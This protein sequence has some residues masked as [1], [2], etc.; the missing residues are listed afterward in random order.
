MTECVWGRKDY[1]GEKKE[2]LIPLLMVTH[3]FSSHP[4]LFLIQ[5][6]HENSA[7]PKQLGLLMQQYL[8]IPLLGEQQ[9]ASALFYGLLVRICLCRPFPIFATPSPVLP[10]S[11]PVQLF[12]KNG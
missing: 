3:I 12:S 9:G 2:E 11:S 4:W 1:F 6:I 8:K 10:P 5:N 7:V